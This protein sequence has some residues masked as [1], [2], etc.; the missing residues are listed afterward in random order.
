[1]DSNAGLNYEESEVKKTF[2]KTII[3]KKNLN[4]KKKNNE[5]FLRKNEYFFT[6][7]SQST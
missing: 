4:V 5:T 3:K 7:T 6:Y 2:R 1:M